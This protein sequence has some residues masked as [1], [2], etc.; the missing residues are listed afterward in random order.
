MWGPWRCRTNLWETAQLF[1]LHLLLLLG[2]RVLDVATDY[3]LG[4]FFREVPVPTSVLYFTKEASDYQYED[5]DEEVQEA[6]GG[7]ENSDEKPEEG[8]EK[9]LDPA[10]DS[11]RKPRY[12]CVAL[13]ITQPPFLAYIF[14]FSPQSK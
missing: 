5:S 11:P 3:K 4:F 12:L 14:K 9:D 7:E 6:E 13:S 2:G 8:P 1:F 10:K